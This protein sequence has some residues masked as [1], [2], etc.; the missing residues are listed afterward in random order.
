MRPDWTRYPDGRKVFFDYGYDVSTPDV[1][2][3]LNRLHEIQDDDSGSAGITLAKYSYLGLGTIVIEDFQEPDVKLDYETGGT[4]AGFDAFGRVVQQLWTDYGPDPD[5]DRDKYTYG[6]DRA[7]NRTYRSN[8]GPSG[9]DE[10]YTYD[11]MYRLETAERGDLTDTPPTGVTSKNFAQQWKTDTGPGL[12]PLGNWTN[13][14]QDD[15]GN[16]TWNLK[17]SRVHNHANEIDVDDDHTNTPGAS[18]TA[19]T[20]TN[21]FDPKYDAPGNMTGVPKPSSLANGLT[22]KYDAWNRLVEVKDGDDVVGKYEYDGLG[23]RIKKHVDSQSPGAPDG[24]D[25]YKHYFYDGIQV[26]ETRD[27]TTESDQPENLSVVYQYIWSARYIDAPILREDV[28]SVGDDR[29]YYLTDAN[30]NVTCL[31]DA[32]G[33]AEERYLYD[34]YGAV[35][36]YEGDWSATQDPTTYNNAILYTGR[37]LDFETGLYYYRARYY[38]AQLGR[39]VN[40]DPIDYGDGPNLYAYA[41]GRPMDAVDPSGLAFEDLGN[42]AYWKYLWEK[43]KCEQDTFTK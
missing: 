8:E 15:D 10:F 32:S 28:F 31:V 39:F 38:H 34:P 27:T 12:D 17:Q 40:R 7:G 29:H 14:W 19:A 23:R 35:T 18:I 26:V 22:C 11:G 42:A 24:I 13:F 2:H 3:Y 33:D 30:F 20:G 9:K 5:V 1:S 16:G 36:V 6:Y 43:F 41:G 25:K 21:W 37:R 4:Y